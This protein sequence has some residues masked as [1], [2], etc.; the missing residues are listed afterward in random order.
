MMIDIRR[1]ARDFRAACRKRNV[2]IGRAFP[3]L[4]SH[5]RVTMGT[6]DEMRQAVEVFGQVLAGGSGA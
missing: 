6:M 4:T 5:I 2:M 3:P 1:D